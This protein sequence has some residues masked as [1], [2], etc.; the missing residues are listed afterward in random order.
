MGCYLCEDLSLRP[1]DPDDADAWNEA[2]VD[3][4]QTFWENPVYRLPDPEPDPETTPMSG[5]PQVVMRCRTCGQQDGRPAE[6]LL[7]ADL[8][9]ARRRIA[10]LEDR[11]A[12]ATAG[13]EPLRVRHVTHIDVGHEYLVFE[14]DGEAYDGP[15]YARREDA[16]P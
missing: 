3:C 14:S 7:R 2:C 16:T 5:V 11:A 1:D 6:A 8:V 9:D 10:E 15:I 12:S 4:D 13:F